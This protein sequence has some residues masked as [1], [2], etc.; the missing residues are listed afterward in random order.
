MVKQIKIITKNLRLWIYLLFIYNFSIK[1]KYNLK[2][3]Y[4]KSSKFEIFKNKNN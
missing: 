4:K 1:K 3:K 2:D